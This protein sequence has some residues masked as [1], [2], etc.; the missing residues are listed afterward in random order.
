MHEPVDEPTQTRLQ[1]TH[2]MQQHTTKRTCHVFKDCVHPKTSVHIH[3]RVCILTKL[4]ECAYSNKT[5]RKRVKS[6]CL[7]DQ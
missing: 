7:L 3:L 2:T 5:N 6:A 4:Q 1:I